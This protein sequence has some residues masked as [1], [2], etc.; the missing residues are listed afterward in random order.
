MLLMPRANSLF[1][2]LT[3]ILSV[4][5][6]SGQNSNSG[7]PY[8]IFGPG[9]IRVRN[10]SQFEGMGSGGTAF[11]SPIQ[12]SLS[13]PASYAALR[14]TNY[15]F[16]LTGRFFK[17][18]DKE[19]ALN[20]MSVNLNNFTLA[21]PVG[22]RFGMGFGLQPFTT[23]DYNILAEHREDSIIRD[24]RFEG[25]GGLNKLF[26]SG[27]WAPFKHVTDSLAIKNL[28]LGLSGNFYFGNINKSQFIAFPDTFDAYNVRVTDLNRLF[29][30]G[31]EYGLQQKFS[32]TSNRLKSDSSRKKIN[33]QIY[34]GLD[35]N[36]K[37]NI[38]ANRSFAVERYTLGS[39]GRTE[40]RDT[41]YFETNEL[42]GGNAMILPQR[43][44]LGISYLRNENLYL[45][46][47]ASYENWAE[48]KFVDKVDTLKNSIGFSF[49]GYFQP[50]SL[51]KFKAGD[52][53]WSIVKYLF[54]I[55]YNSG[56]LK[57]K[58]TDVSNLGI[59]FGLSLPVR[60]AKSPIE[61]YSTLNIGVELGQRGSFE[62]DLIRERYVQVNLG[63]SLVDRWFVKRKYD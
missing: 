1:F 22:N 57:F 5:C 33:H 42:R 35:H 61:R 19:S 31:L 43:L 29:G 8:S 21:F 30:F 12:V 38:N 6:A 48:Y 54:G 63:F 32:F 51:N 40:I 3:L 60:G 15:N 16:G 10:L 53:Y 27:A 25:L 41:A 26:I 34:L 44:S 36:L 47:D 23:V 13:N 58:E 62:Q 59:T 45:Q 20:K 49:G 14:I 28:S 7:S 50:M 46:A 2:L 55:K 18:E 24:E 39:T 52:S 56:N 37:A 9:D 4:L 17:L 11:N